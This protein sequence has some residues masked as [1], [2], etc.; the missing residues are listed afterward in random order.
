ME[1]ARGQSRL[2]WVVLVFSGMILGLV[3]CQNDEA[4][5]L[6]DTKENE[7][8]R[9]DETPQKPAIPGTAENDVNK[10]GTKPNLAE[11][12]PPAMSCERAYEEFKTKALAGTQEDRKDLVRQMLLTMK[13]KL[14]KA[15]ENKELEADCLAGQKDVKGLISV[16]GLK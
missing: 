10:P 7:P 11:T 15:C 8:V 6:K 1:Y 5:T 13:G 3:A 12:S 2:F 9:E 14:L 4:E 16:C